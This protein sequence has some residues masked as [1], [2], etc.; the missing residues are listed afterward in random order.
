MAD[1]SAR[2]VQLMA[3]LKELDARLHDIIGELDEPTS[4]DWEESATEREGVEV[5]ESL[6]DT[7]KREIAAI[8]AALQ[9]MKDGE[10]GFCVKCGD[11]I[12]DE[13]LD[14]VP[15]TPFCSKCAQ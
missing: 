7:G 4:K 5:L 3:R 1:L 9:R 13:R 10:Y 2:R 12:P 8:R 15:A 14:L 6:G 11:Q